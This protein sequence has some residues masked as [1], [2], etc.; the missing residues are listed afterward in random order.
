MNGRCEISKDVPCVWQMIYDR[1]SSLGLLH[2]LEDVAPIRNWK[3]SNAAGPRKIV[4]EDL[5]LPVALPVDSLKV[6]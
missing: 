6:K 1:L 5:R 2:R 3:T 4:R